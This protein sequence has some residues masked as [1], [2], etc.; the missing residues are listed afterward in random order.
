MP[1]R[2]FSFRADPAGNAARDAAH[3]ET[4]TTHMLTAAIRRGDPDALRRH[5]EAWFDKALA[6]AHRLTRRDESFCLDVVQEAMLRVV[7]SMPVMDT[8]AELGRWMGVVIRSAAIDLLRREQ[9]HKSRE[10]NVAPRAD[11]NHADHASDVN[12]RI[13]WLRRELSEV[14]EQDRELI[15]LRFAGDA[16]VHKAAR[17][18]GLTDGAAHGRLRRVIAALRS[19]ARE[20]FHD[21]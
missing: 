5:Y 12:E 21:H 11:A 1:F 15:L 7:R 8:E 10:R 13:E 19:A 20:K 18:A 9:R 16:T 17:A 2:G 3:L 6:L 14:A 4:S